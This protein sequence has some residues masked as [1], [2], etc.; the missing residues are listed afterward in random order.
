MKYDEK[1]MVKREHV[2]IIVKELRELG[3]EIPQNLDINNEH[4]LANLLSLACGGGKY[5]LKPNKIAQIKSDEFSITE[6]AIKHLCEKSA[7]NFDS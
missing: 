6:G 3:S 4:S 7:T 2:K 1:S 5:R